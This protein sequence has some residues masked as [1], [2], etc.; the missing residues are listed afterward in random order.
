MKSSES[1]ANYFARPAHNDSN[2]GGKSVLVM[3]ETFWTESQ[4]V[5]GVPM[6]NVKLIVILN[7]VS[8]KMKETLFSNLFV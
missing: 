6:I 2:K 5:K 3:K 7:V 1:L 4:L 8:E